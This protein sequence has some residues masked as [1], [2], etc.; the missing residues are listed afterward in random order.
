MSV[1]DT[2]VDYSRDLC[3]VCMQDV[4]MLADGLAPHVCSARRAMRMGRK[5]TG[6][7]VL[8]SVPHPDFERL[9]AEGRE[10]LGLPPLEDGE[11]DE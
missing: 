7:N 5:R 9:H 8:P 3:E 4:A 11:D 2:S 6:R 10:D 1:L